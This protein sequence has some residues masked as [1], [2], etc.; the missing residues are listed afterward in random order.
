MQHEPENEK[1][2]R[3]ERKGKRK[4]EKEKRKREKQFSIYSIHVT[5]HIRAGELIGYSWQ[6]RLL[7]Y[8]TLS[9]MCQ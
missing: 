6:R 2:G 4:E 3:G 8:C 7:K 5:A 9:W 1:R